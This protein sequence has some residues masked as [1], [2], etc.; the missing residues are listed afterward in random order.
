MYRSSY[1]STGGT[2]NNANI[3]R[4]TLYANPLVAP[5]HVGFFFFGT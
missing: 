2:V 1:D 5:T 4:F 3:L